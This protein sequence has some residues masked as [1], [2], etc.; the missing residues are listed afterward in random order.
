M[1]IR[2]ISAGVA[3][4]IFIPVVIF[5]GTVVL[6]I[7]I[8]IVSVL[9]LFEMLRCC[10]VHKQGLFVLPYYI[11]ALAIPTVFY[12][13]VRF[14]WDLPLAEMMLLLMF[15][16][17]IWAYPAAIFSKGKLSVT[18]AATASIGSMYVL[19]GLNSILYIRQI[20]APSGV[21][22]FVLVFLG[23]WI[24][25]SAAYF[26][27]R[28]FGKHKLIPDVSP[29]KTVEGSIGGI[30]FC[31][32]FFGLY[33]FLVENTISG[34]E[35]DANYVALLV[36]AFFISIVS[37]IGDLAMSLLKRHYQIK[38]FGKIMPGHG[39]VIDRFDSV[40]A[41]AIVLLICCSVSD[42]LFGA[43]LFTAVSS[44]TA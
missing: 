36:S 16:F 32:L 27:G 24:T 30:L 5:S 35:M 15:F 11:A 22:I 38:D 37:Q 1:K 6:P 40:F 17:L 8:A 25:D 41:V 21:Y 9:A 43:N 12:L 4:L 2:L 14:S 26:C 31:M 42:G 28:A 29:K 18:D 13:T 10:G 33:G 39:G 7:A 3:L 23:A 44:V 19:A 20:M 34:G